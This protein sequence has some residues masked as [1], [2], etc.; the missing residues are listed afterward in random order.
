[1]SGIIFLGAVVIA[2]AII[3]GVATVALDANLLNDANIDSNSIDIDVNANNLIVTSED[4]L[5]TQTA[6]YTNNNESSNNN[7][8][9]PNVNY[10]DGSEENKAN[11]SKYECI[12]GNEYDIVQGEYTIRAEMVGQVD[13]LCEVFATLTKAPSF[14]AFAIGANA[15]CYLTAAELNSLGPSTNISTLNCS[16]Y[17]YELAKLQ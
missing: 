17:L 12:I 13:G 14:E 2:F 6:I 5:G 15:T 11:K 4:E 7:D 9:K 10:N 1:M 8:S 16:G 3:G